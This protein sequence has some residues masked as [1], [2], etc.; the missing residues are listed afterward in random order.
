MANHSNHVYFGWPW[1]TMI[2]HGWPWL[3][4]VDLG[5]PWLIMVGHG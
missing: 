1:L 4:M 2:D 3:T 5:G